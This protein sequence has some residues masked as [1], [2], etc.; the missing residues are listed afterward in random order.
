ME[1]RITSEYQSIATL[2]ATATFV[3]ESSDPAQRYFS[4]GSMVL[5]SNDFFYAN[6]IP[7][8]QPLFDENGEL[9]AQ[10]FFV[11]NMGVG[12]AGTEENDELPA[13][14]VFFGQRSP[15][16]G[17]DENGVMLTMADN[18]SL[19]RFFPIADGGILADERFATSEFSVS[20]YR[21][22]KISFSTEPVVDPVIS[23]PFLTKARLNDDQTMP[24]VHIRA[25]GRAGYD[26]KSDAVSYTCVS[27]LKKYSN[28]TPA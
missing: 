14:T 22:V 7:P 6:A 19:V 10:D 8:A 4:Y 17:V 12:D 20:G 21:L 3:I 9:K 16:T 11:T 23:D 26:V 1:Q 24:R 27:P 15:N 18:E 25:S 13:N 2:V 28:G 5:P